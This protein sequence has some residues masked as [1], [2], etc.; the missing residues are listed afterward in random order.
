MTCTDIERRSKE[1]KAWWP[2]CF[3]QGELGVSKG[4]FQTLYQE[5]IAE[6]LDKNIA[7]D[8]DIAERNDK[9]NAS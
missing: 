7:I 1:Q 5:K 9:I 6:L 4:R 2:N 8:N 3:W